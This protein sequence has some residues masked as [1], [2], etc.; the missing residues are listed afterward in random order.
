[1]SEIT[2][3]DRTT[4]LCGGDEVAFLPLLPVTTGG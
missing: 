2:T 3:V 1:M 4:E